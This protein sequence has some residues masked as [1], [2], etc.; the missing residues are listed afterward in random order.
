MFLQVN[1]LE[2]QFKDHQA[3]KTTTLHMLACLLSP[4]K[5][6]ISYTR[7]KRLS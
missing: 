1:Q 2:K 5:G 6:S 4:T 7:E 3:G